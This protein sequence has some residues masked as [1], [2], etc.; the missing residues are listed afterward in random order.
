MRRMHCTADRRRSHRGTAATLSEDTLETQSIAHIDSIESCHNSQQQRSI[1]LSGGVHFIAQ[2][3]VTSS[4]A[5]CGGSGRPP[6][7]SGAL[8][9]P[10]STAPIFLEIACKFKILHTCSM[11]VPHSVLLPFVEGDT[12]TAPRSPSPRIDGGVGTDRRMPHLP[13]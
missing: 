12:L 13:L 8:L 1:A 7:R 2:Y 10:H 9:T 6:P 5:L 4:D 3:R 11:N